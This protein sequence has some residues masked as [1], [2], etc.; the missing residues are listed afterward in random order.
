[1]AAKFRRPWLIWL[2]FILVVP[3]LVFYDYLFPPFEF[4]SERVDYI[5]SE[6]KEFP[7]DLS[8]YFS[9]LAY[10]VARID[11]GA[12]AGED[13]SKEQSYFEKGLG[14]Y[15]QLS[16][17][18]NSKLSSVDS[19]TGSDVFSKRA[20]QTRAQLEGN[21]DRLGNLLQKLDSNLAFYQRNS[22]HFGLRWFL[23]NRSK[24][25]IHK[26]CIQIR[27]ILSFPKFLSD[28]SLPTLIPQPLRGDFGERKTWLNRPRRS[29]SLESDVALYLVSL[30][31]P[32][33]DA[34]IGFSIDTSAGSQVKA[35]V[36]LLGKDPIKLYEYVR[37]RVDY[38]VG[39]GLVQDP[40]QVLARGYGNDQE[41]AALLISL[42]RQAGIHARFVKG[43]IEVPAKQLK[44]WIGVSDAESAI[45]LLNRNGILAKVGVSKGD[46]STVEL[47]H[48]WVRAYIPYDRARGAVIHTGGSFWVDLDPSFKDYKRGFWRDAGNEIG[49]EA[50]SFLTDIKDAAVVNGDSAYATRVP[51][52]LIINKLDGWADKLMA[53]ADV[54][55]LK[56][57]DLYQKQEITPEHLSALPSSLPYE[58]TS[59]EWSGPSL[60]ADSFFQAKISLLDQNGKQII[61]L[62]GNFLT[63]CQ[64]GLMLSYIPASAADQEELAKYQAASD[65]PAYLIQVI[66]VLKQ[67][68]KEGL[69]GTPVSLGQMQYLSVDISGPGF[70]GERSMRP[71][72]AGSFMSL[73]FNGRGI[74]V[75]DLYSRLP[76]LRLLR[77][78]IQ[79]G[80]QKSAEEVFSTI[81]NLV[82]LAYFQEL[83]HLLKLGGDALEV[84]VTRQPSVLTIGYEIDVSEVLGVGISARSLGVTLSLDRN[85]IVP[86]SMNS[87]PVNEKQFMVVAGLT[88]SALEHNILIQSLGRDAVSSLR[89]IQAAS[90]TGMPVFTLNK[91]NYASVKNYLQIPA[92]IV[93]SVVDFCDSGKIVTIPRQSFEYVGYK[94]IG[95]IVYDPATGNS[96][97]FLEQGLAGGVMPT[98]IL[99]P[100]KLL[101]P[102]D[103]GAFFAMANPL[104]AWVDLAKEVTESISFRYAPAVSV[105]NQWFKNETLLDSATFIASAIAIS[106]PIQLVTNRPEIYQF[107]V[108][109]ELFSPRLLGSLGQ[110]EVSAR[111]SRTSDWKVSM[112]N[113]SNTSVRSYSGQG[114][115]VS[116][117]WNGRQNDQAPEFVPDGTY[118][119]KLEAALVN[120]GGSTAERTRQITLDATPPACVLDIENN[121]TVS[122]I[123]V[124]PGTANDE[125][126]LEYDLQAQCQGQTNWTEL[127]RETQPR[128][129]STLAMFD[130]TAFPAGSC[131]IQMNVFD[132]AGNQSTCS[133]TLQNTAQGQ[134]PPTVSFDW[135]LDGSTVSGEEF[136]QA[137]ASDDKGVVSVEIY[138]G[139]E[140]F[141]YFYNLSPLPTSIYIAKLDTFK[142]PNGPLTLTAKAFDEKGRNSEAKIT[143]Q[144]QNKIENFRAEPQVFSPDKDGIDDYITFSARFPQSIWK[145]EVR[146][147]QNALIKTWSNTGSDFRLSWDGKNESGA[148]ASPAKYRGLLTLD[149]GD[150]A[151]VPFELQ[152]INRPPRLEIAS[153]KDQQEITAPTKIIGM[154]QDNDLQSWDLSWAEYLP[155][156][157][158]QQLSYTPIT[159]GTTP[160]TNQ[161][162]ADFDPTG[163]TNG[164]YVLRLKAKD[165]ENAE[166]TLY[167]EFIVSGQL[168]IGLFTLTFQDLSVPLAGI[169]ITIA[170]TYSSIERN[171]LHEFGYGWTMAI[172]ELDAREDHNRNVTLNLPDGRRVTFEYQLYPHT[173]VTYLARWN[174]PDGVYAELKMNTDNRVLF[175]PLGG[176]LLGFFHDYL[177]YPEPTP[178]ED[179]VIPGY[180]LTLEDGT[181]LEVKRDVLERDDLT[182]KPVKWGPLHLESATD[183]NNNKL[184]FDKYGIHHSSGVEIKFTRDDKDRI[185]S[186]KDPAGNFINY[187]YDQN[188]DLAKVQY[189][190][191]SDIQYI[192]YT[193]SQAKHYLKDIIDP[194]GNRAIRNDY[195]AEGNLIATYDANNKKIEYIHKPDSKQEI[196]KDRLGNI[197]VYE[198]DDKGNVV[199]ETNALGYRTEYEYDSNGNK[200]KEIDALGNVLTFKYDSK[201]Y[202]TERTDAAGNKTSMVYDSNGNLI[203]RQDA[204][205]HVIRNEYDAR[206]NVLRTTDALGNST[207][208]QYDQNGKILKEIDTAGN[209]T[210][211]GYDDKGRMNS[212]KDALGGTI[213]ADLDAF[214]HSVNIYIANG[215]IHYSYDDRGRVISETDPIGN[216]KSYEYNKAGQKTAEMD[217]LGRRTEYVYDNLG[218]KIKEIYPDKTSS[219]TVY[220][221]EG[222]AIETID[223]MERSTK[224]TYN[225]DG[226]LIKVIYPDGNSEEFT[227]DALG[228]AIEKKDNRG[229]ISKNEYDATGNRIKLTDILGNVTSYTYDL[230]RKIL[231]RILPNGATY[232]Y[233][234][235]ALG[236]KISSTY[237]D[238]TISTLT[239]NEMG[240]MT[241]KVDRNGNKTEYDYDALGREVKTTDVEGK[242]TVYEYDSKLSYSCK[243][244]WLMSGI[245]DP[246]GHTTKLK[247]DALGRKVEQELPGGQIAS[248]TYQGCCG[249][250]NS[251]TDF[252]GQTTS[253]EMDSMNRITKRVYHDGTTVQFFY[254]ND[255]QVKK[256]ISPLGERKYAYDNLGRLIREDKEDSQFIAYK[257]DSYGDL[258]G[259]EYSGGHSVS[260]EYDRYGRP[261]NIISEAGNFK[262]EYDNWGRKTGLLY[263]NGARAKYYYDEQNRI[264]K[265]EQIAKDGQIAR[266]E[267]V[268]DAVGNVLNM[269]QNGNMIWEYSYDNLYRIKSEALREKYTME[270]DY[271]SFGNRIHQNRDGAITEYKYDE[272]DRLLEEKTPEAIFQYGYDQN[273]NIISKS[274]GNV[275]LSYEWNYDNKPVRV[276]KNGQ[277]IGKVV[278]DF[279]GNRIKE[280]TPSGER[281]FLIDEGNPTGYDQILREIINGNESVNYIYGDDLYSQIRNGSISYYHYDN[282]GSTR[283]LSDAQGKF[284]NNYDY[285]AFG[286]IENSNVGVSNTSLFTGEQYD[287]ILSSYYLRARHYDTKL[288]R[289]KSMDLIDLNHAMNRYIYSNNNPVINIDYSGH[290]EQDVHQSWTGQ[291]LVENR[292]FNIKRVIR[293]SEA[294]E[295]ADTGHGGL[296]QFYLPTHSTPLLWSWHKMSAFLYTLSRMNDTNEKDYD[297]RFGYLLHV[298]Q[299]SYSHCEKNWLDNEVCYHMYPPR[300]VAEARYPDKRERDKNCYHVIPYI[301]FTGGPTGY[302]APDFYSCDKFSDEWAVIDCDMQWTT[303]E[304]IDEYGHKSREYSHANSAVIYYTYELITLIHIATLLALL[305]GI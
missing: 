28:A 32:P 293:I 253:Y 8:S 92:K 106:G 227:Y 102:T 95:Y 6:V 153:P 156:K 59:E 201:G 41:Q 305:G 148:L 261:S 225:A 134:A 137:T 37:N 284:V 188:G 286:E 4:S 34:D 116:I 265:I 89:M 76:Q 289:F 9:E 249:S 264:N 97:Y 175:S 260:Y 133:R 86:V 84:K 250:L 51:E 278:Y 269:T 248:W 115:Q 275:S 270:Y 139:S 259:I 23:A 14:L 172:E 220:D 79:Q 252:N 158:Y 111:L 18:V 207:Q 72:R 73:V 33:A 100:S 113:S 121:K 57:L 219:S 74:G 108:R 56:S 171:N 226:R 216:T 246:R 61:S 167:R 130:S 199:S 25:R 75:S 218:Q 152:M 55:R 49:L 66:P 62:S 118:T 99:N 178:Y 295:A 48:T 26:I 71:L 274:G 297:K 233:A 217:A 202:M 2:V 1:M 160:F 47:Q 209:A 239:Y 301:G 65:V 58:V 69:K 237:P 124:I 42:Y 39:S 287:E 101:L 63:L 16:A 258:T 169:P 143:I 290:Y 93:P 279:S 104:L 107:Y 222:R 163:L 194:L 78:D 256:V 240:L 53:Y 272:N 140:R 112:I 144:L 185:T 64:T 181:V 179:S 127:M 203:E 273:G 159:S 173:P 212:I 245:T 254:N 236:R 223:Q 129:Q 91:D 208:Y 21:L 31:S 20:R 192:Y 88:S 36:D 174:A 292:L 187:T 138:A 176:G 38:V 103:P 196:I 285:T 170:R 276:V 90:K 157:A 182:G 255:G 117:F 211:F 168:K 70:S 126:F 161:K 267:Y 3:I 142:Y 164:F 302:C 154:V 257:Y 189:Q 224:N 114:E 45:R 294:D 105:I 190:D 17:E 247:Y 283:K 280:I 43:R 183:K 303:R 54:N 145:L 234:Y 81:F 228:R 184:T 135:P 141:G 19:K 304:L 82:G 149:S 29:A 67:P 271:D 195:D 155:D 52:E 162:I 205:G 151:S 221:L 200:T 198:Y 268:F 243:V 177:A 5:V 266:F 291:W 288:G 165:T 7:P 22:G 300:S 282:I 83:D 80:K 232:K 40:E 24:H 125:H 131:T 235:D 186:V 193:D 262:Y 122:K 132:Q 13:L 263:P 213:T 10:L 98:D 238:N 229:N 166:Q 180:K 281:N 30:P 197:T 251:Y 215:T 231:Q 44:D 11:R 68:G 296:S 120:Q 15:A 191:N 110:A 27:K 299:D 244:G 50:I 119:V 85:A 123:V 210:T 214:G 60:G 241:T 77:E 109:P 147:E 204:M 94:G 46:Y 87:T 277:E 96:G 146:T 12:A 230:N 136:V 206:G 298:V 242:M 150:T 128:V 35:L